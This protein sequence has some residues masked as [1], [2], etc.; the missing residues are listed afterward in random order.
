MIFSPG[1]CK[2]NGEKER[3]THEIGID[4]L[5]VWMCYW[6]WMGKYLLIIRYLFGIDMLAFGALFQEIKKKHLLLLLVFFCST[7]QSIFVYAS[8]LS[9]F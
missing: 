1:V 5:E 2:Q 3:R 4:H 9:E 7:I 8:I 6:M